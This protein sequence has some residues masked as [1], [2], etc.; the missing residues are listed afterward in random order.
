MPCVLCWPAG[1]LARWRMAGAATRAESPGRIST[2][3]T[4]LTHS[5]LSH[6]TPTT[7][8]RATYPHKADPLIDLRA[9][10]KC[11]GGRGGRDALWARG[12]GVSGTKH[13]SMRAHCH[14]PPWT[15]PPA[16][17]P[18]VGPQEDA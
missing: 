6:P 12:A 10:L 2:S 5:L 11:A 14:R 8:Y 7:A 13:A 15:L 4:C 9:Q 1:W 17:P 3:I 16:P 18:P